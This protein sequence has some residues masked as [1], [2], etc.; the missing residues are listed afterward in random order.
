MKCKAC[1]TCCVAISVS[2]PIPGMPH[3]KSAGV[4]CIH[5]TIEGLCGLFGK[6]ERPKIFI[7]KI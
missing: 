7:K 4:R 5:L 6:P 1:R 3:G 2:S